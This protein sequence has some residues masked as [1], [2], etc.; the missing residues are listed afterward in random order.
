[1]IRVKDVTPGAGAGGTEFRVTLKI[2]TGLPGPVPRTPTAEVHW[3][4]DVMVSRPGGPGSRRQRLRRS[5]GRRPGLSSS[6]AAA[7]ELPVTP[8]DPTGNLAES[9]KFTETVTVTPDSRAQ[10][11][12]ASHGSH[13]VAS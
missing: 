12:T 11:E 5:R 1:M 7:A 3:H 6:P 9:R 10:L 8:P 2:Q 13:S 4:R